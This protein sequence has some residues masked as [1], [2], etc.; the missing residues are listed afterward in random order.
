MLLY[1]Y[2]YDPRSGKY[3]AVIMNI[4]RLAGGLT[5]LVLGGVLLVMFSLVRREGTRGKKLE[6]GRA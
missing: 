5:V 3:G 1:C 2:H 4:L 6:T